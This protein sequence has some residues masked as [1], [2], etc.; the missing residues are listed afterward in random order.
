MLRAMSSGTSTSY[1]YETLKVTT[2]VENVVQVEINRPEK[3]NA[4]NRAFWR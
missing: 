1:E 3:R 2:P 4:M